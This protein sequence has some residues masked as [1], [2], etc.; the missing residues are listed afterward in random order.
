MSRWFSLE[1][2]KDEWPWVVE[3]SSKLALIISALEALAIVVALKVYHGEEPR[4]N[5]SSNRIVPT[6]TEGTGRPS[7]N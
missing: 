7:T 1:I 6:T 2:T 3:K 4:K 5:R